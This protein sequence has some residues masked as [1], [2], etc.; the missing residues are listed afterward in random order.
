MLFDHLGFGA[1]DR[2][3]YGDRHAAI[4]GYAADLLEILDALQ[5]ERMTCVGHPFGATIGMLAIGVLRNDLHVMRW[6]T[7]SWSRLR[8]QKSP[9]QP[10]DRK[11]VTH[12]QAI[13]GILDAIRHPPSAN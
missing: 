8:L 1:S 4:V 2:S 10:L 11:L 7:T 5:L 3:A 12:D 6:P 9:G 13:E